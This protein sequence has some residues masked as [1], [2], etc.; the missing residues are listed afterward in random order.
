[1]LTHYR[2]GD[3]GDEAEYDEE[4][5]EE[6]KVGSVS[7]QEESES[8]KRQRE[9]IEAQKRAQFDAMNA[10]RLLAETEQPTQASS[11][12]KTTATEVV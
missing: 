3:Y 5:E 10:N 4:A 12:A 2:S 9:L 6:A 1:M 7:T 8:D 11:D